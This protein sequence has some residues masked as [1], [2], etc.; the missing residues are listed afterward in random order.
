MSFSQNTGYT[1][2]I[3]ESPGLGLRERVLIQGMGRADAGSKLSVQEPL[4]NWPTQ[5]AAAF[6]NKEA[7]KLKKNNSKRNL[8]L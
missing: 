5:I 3:I 1:F 7:R 8:N 4:L 6:D 2:Q